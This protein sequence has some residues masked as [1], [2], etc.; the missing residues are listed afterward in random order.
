MKNFKSYIFAA[1][2]FAVLVVLAGAVGS[3][4]SPPAT[5]QDV[6]VVNTAASPVPTQAQGT[7]NIAGSVE[8]QQ[9]GIW[10]VGIAGTPTIQVGNSQAQPIPVL[11]TLQA[12][13]E[14]VMIEL[15][16]SLTPF[17][18]SLVSDEYILPSGKRLVVEQAYLLVG[19]GAGGE[20]IAYLRVYNQ[21]PSGSPNRHFPL[22]LSKQ[23]T[24]ANYDTHVVSG[25][26]KMYI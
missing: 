19:L 14:P 1:I 2:G 20:A 9:S 25:P 26:T 5:A 8:A 21:G 6:K 16:Y 11:D 24:L 18:N 10:N 17:G 12:A 15:G 22:L 13:R 4:A 7:T 23:G 3:K